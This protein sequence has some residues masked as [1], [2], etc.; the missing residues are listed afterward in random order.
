[1]NNIFISVFLQDVEICISVYICCNI[2][3][4]SIFMKISLFVKDIYSRCL[5]FSITSSN[6]RT[7]SFR[8]KIS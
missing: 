6:L 4:T 1:M 8:N 5:K 3:V 2:F 7:M